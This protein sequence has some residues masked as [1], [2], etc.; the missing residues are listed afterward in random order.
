MRT[1]GM[2]RENRFSSLVSRCH[3]PF[4]RRNG[5]KQAPRHQHR[6]SSAGGSSPWLELAGEAEGLAGEGSRAF[7]ERRA[8]QR[9]HDRGGWPDAGPI[10]RSE[11]EY[12]MWEKRTDALM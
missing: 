3:F 5:A 4:A 2:R 8:M 10:D 11:H 9:V 6:H 7:K 12:T 1:P